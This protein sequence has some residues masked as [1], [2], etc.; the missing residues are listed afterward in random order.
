MIETIADRIV[1]KGFGTVAIFMLEAGK[2]LA[3]LGSQTLVFFQPI[4]GI[5]MERWIELLEDRQRIEQLILA[6]EERLEEPTN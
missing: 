3:F 4:L 1:E 6:I 2:P 5:S